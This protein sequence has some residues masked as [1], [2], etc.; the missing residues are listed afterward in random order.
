[1]SL[2]ISHAL[3]YTD[4]EQE[5]YSFYAQYLNLQVQDILRFNAEQEWCILNNKELNLSIILVQVNSTDYPKATIIIHTDDCILEYCKLKGLG[6]PSI[7]TPEYSQLGISINCDDPAGNH[8]IIIEQRKY[9]D[10]QI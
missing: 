6:L 3:I 7:S 2:S 5:C 1:M 9:I 8:I 4:C 10:T